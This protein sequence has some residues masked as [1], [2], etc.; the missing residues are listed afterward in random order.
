MGAAQKPQAFLPYSLFWKSWEEKCFCGLLPAVRTPCQLL[1]KQKS[2]AP[3]KWGWV[4]LTSTV[5]HT[6][7]QLNWRRSLAG[8]SPWRCK[9]SDMTDYHTH[10]HTH[11]HREMDLIFIYSSVDRYLGCFHVLAIVNSAAMNIGEHIPLWIRAFKLHH[12][13]I[14]PS[15]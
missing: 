4:L 11:T 7:L 15:L 6:A 9:E 2:A 13:Q 8:Y 5:V 3:W 14:S 1:C 10:T 12:L